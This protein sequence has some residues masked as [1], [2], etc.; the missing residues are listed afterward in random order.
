[1]LRNVS[2]NEAIRHFARIE[3]A[4]PRRVPLSTAAG[5]RLAED[6]VVR[7]PRPM[8]PLAARNGIAVAASMFAGKPRR[9]PKFLGADVHVV[10]TGMP[11]P[12]ETDAVLPLAHAERRPRGWFAVQAVLPGEGVAAPES[13]AA[14]GEVIGRAGERVTFAFAIACAECGVEDVVVRQPVVDVIFNAPSLP[15]PSEQQVGLICGAI[16]GSGSK[17]GAIAFAGGD[18]DILR[19]TLSHSSAD[20]ITVI[21][22]VGDGPGDTTMAAIADAGEAVFHGVRLS[23]GGTMGF[24]FVG[25]RPVFASPGGIANMVAA[26][27]VLSWHFARRSFGRPP[28]EPQLQRAPLAAAIP[29]SPHGARLVIARH[30]DGVITPFDESVLSPRVLANANASIF[31]PEGARAHRRGQIVPF[32]RMGISM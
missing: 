28:M 7:R 5:L 26:N 23:P 22:G 27:I 13:Y 6:V 20:V 1:M 18:R 8:E 2:V 30:A 14:P 32:L 16:R 3:P 9:Q 29:A 15:R 24:G 17:L 25:G 11:M 19:D 10:E 4:S 31:V 12:R 21:G